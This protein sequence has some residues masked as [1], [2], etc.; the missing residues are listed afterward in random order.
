MACPAVGQPEVVRGV[1]DRVG[2]AGDQDL[3]AGVLVVESL[4]QPDSLH[5]ARLDEGLVGVEQDAPE[6]AV[7]DPRQELHRRALADLHGDT[8]GAIQ[9]C[10][11]DR[12][13]RDG[14]LLRVEVG[15]H[16]ARGARLREEAE[17]Q[18]SIGRSAPGLDAAVGQLELERDIALWHIRRADDLHLDLVRIDLGGSCGRRRRWTGLGLHGIDRC[19][20]GGRS[21]ACATGT[22][23]PCATGPCATGAALIGR[24]LHGSAAELAGAGARYARR[25]GVGHVDRR[26]T[27]ADRDAAARLDTERLRRVDEQ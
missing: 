21:T 8:A 22:A 2:V 24:V 4:E 9:A 13:A 10:T 27:P 25:R 17:P 6:A 1:A 5:R 7:V 15:Q 14:A 23:G 18:K 16:Q 19:T 3:A 26:R 11:G 12:R 20:R